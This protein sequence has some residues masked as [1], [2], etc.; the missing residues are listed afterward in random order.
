MN[1]K[2]TH[3]IEADIIA[4]TTT[5]ERPSIIIKVALMINEVL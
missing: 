2:S 4:R 3:D 1:E 5:D